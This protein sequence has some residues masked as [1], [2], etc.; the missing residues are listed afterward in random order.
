MEILRLSETLKTFPL[1]P[2]WILLWIE[3]WLN[4][5]FMPVNSSVSVINWR[6]Y[7]GRES[8]IFRGPWILSR[9]PHSHSET[10]PCPSA[11]TSFQRCLGKVALQLPGP[12]GSLSPKDND[13]V[14]CILRLAREG[15]RETAVTGTAPGLP[16]RKARGSH[17]LISTS[18]S[19][20]RHS[21]LLLGDTFLNLPIMFN[22][23]SAE[24]SGLR[25]HVQWAKVSK[26][27][28]SS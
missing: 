7:W 13:R 6:P 15:L 18:S 11:S 19:R 25:D 3:L 12:L 23:M 21:A 22:S 24:S 27:N 28:V 17:G 8:W 26:T 10:P 20:P 14:V 1:P 16:A 9:I 2:M 5:W 4:A